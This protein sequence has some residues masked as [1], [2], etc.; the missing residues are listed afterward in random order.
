MQPLIELSRSLLFSS[1]YKT[2]SSA[3]IMPEAEARF[4][5]YCDINRLEARP[6][7]PKNDA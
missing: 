7:A 4:H 2:R 3:A 6:A 1:A 5:T